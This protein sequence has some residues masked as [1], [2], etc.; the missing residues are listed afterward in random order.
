[1][2]LDGRVAG[3]ERL[4]RELVQRDAVA[5]PVE[6]AHLVQAVERLVQLQQALLLLAEE[7][8][9][10]VHLLGRGAELSSRRELCARGRSSSMSAS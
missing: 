6:A 3:S 4:A 7:R 8:L 2:H 10:R 5:P 1:M 9:Q